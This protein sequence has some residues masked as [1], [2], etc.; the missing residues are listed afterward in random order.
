[1]NSLP[2]R[3]RNILEE[4]ILACWAIHVQRQHTLTVLWVQVMVHLIHAATPSRSAGGSA[5]RWEVEYADTARGGLIRP[6]IACP[7]RS[8]GGQPILV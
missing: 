5:Q 6:W 3:W 4:Y 7:F 8:E 1:M 2:D